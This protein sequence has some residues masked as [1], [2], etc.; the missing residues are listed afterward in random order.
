MPSNTRD[1]VPAIGRGQ[2]NDLPT[3]LQIPNHRAAIGR[4]RGE[5][6]LDLAVPRHARDVLQ[7]LALWPRREGLIKAVNVPAED[8]KSEGSLLL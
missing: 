1:G 4:G 8:L 5:N 6:V 7:T 2:M 3:T